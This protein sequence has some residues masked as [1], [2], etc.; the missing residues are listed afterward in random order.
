MHNS[1]FSS[2]LSTTEVSGLLGDLVTSFHSV[3]LLFFKEAVGTSMLDVTI[4]KKEIMLNV[5]LKKSAGKCRSAPPS[6]Y[7]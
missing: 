1:N 6:P 4:K 7:L 3:N 2:C 5:E